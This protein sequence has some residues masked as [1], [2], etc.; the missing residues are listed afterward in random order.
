MTDTTETWIGGDGGPLVLLQAG[1]I[2][3]WRG[4]ADFNVSRMNGGT[5]ETDYDVICEATSPL[6]HRHGRDM[7]VLDDSS[8]S[9]RLFA[10]PDGRIVVEQPYYGDGAEGDLLT[11]AAAREPTA[12]FA[13]SVLDDRLRLQVGADGAEAAN[14]GCAEVAITPGTW[15]C[16]AYR[17]DAGFGIILSRT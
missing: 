7:L 8:W 11:R 3:A 2:A 12:R 17:D 10:A 6:V 4:A 15:R 9:G 1:A 13:F 5:V 14:Y 16:A